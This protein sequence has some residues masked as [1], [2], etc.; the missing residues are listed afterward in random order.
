MNP[1]K[2]QL[3]VEVWQILIN[4]NKPGVLLGADDTKITFTD[5]VPKN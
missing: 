2:N 1:E 3:M 5:P 4:S